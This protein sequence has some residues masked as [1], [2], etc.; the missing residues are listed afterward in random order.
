MSQAGTCERGC[1]EHKLKLVPAGHY[2]HLTAVTA[3]AR[4]RAAAFKAVAQQLA[5]H[6]PRPEEYQDAYRSVQQAAR[7]TL[8]AYPDHSTEDEDSERPA[9]PATTWWC[10]ECGAID[11]PQPCLGICIW[12][13]VEWVNAALSEQQWT[14]LIAERDTEQRLRLLLRLVASVTP[15]DSQWQ[16][17]W[18]ALQAHARQTLDAC[19]HA[20]SAAATSQ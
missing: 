10:A 15:R 9:E 6:R 11:A 2:D 18:H 20:A 7:L 19:K 8:R 1:S 14:R 4:I 17:G 16:R 12:H 3:D 5:T 13:R